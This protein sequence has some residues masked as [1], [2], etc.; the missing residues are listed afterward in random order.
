MDNHDV[1]RLTS[2]L[3]NP[4]HVFPAYC[5]LFTIPGIP[6]IYY[7]SEW[8][9]PGCRTPNDDRALRPAI[10]PITISIDP[11]Y[12]DLPDYIA[13]LSQIRLGSSALQIGSY[14]QI[15][16]GHEQFAFIRESK[17][18]QIL[19]ALNSAQTARSLDLQDIPRE[20]GSCIDL[21]TGE[22][23]DCQGGKI[24]V[25]LMPPNSARV[26]RL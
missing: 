18:E 14:R 13:K 9:T 25:P 10:N 21:L 12:K 22:T 2:N 6:S 19:I 17:Q 16:V 23:L 15:F 4:K 1:N 11:A 5:L 24:H 20:T 7:G 8:G 26:L 3:T